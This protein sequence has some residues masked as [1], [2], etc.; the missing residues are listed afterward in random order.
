MKPGLEVG[1]QARLNRIVD[2]S[3]SITLGTSISATV[4]ATPS[5]IH[6]MEYTAT[7][8]LAPY[9]DEGESSVGI[10]VNVEHTAATPVGSDVW[11]IATVTA[12]EK[13]VISFDVEAF[14][15]AGKIGRGKHRRAII[16]MEK[17]AERLKK[18]Q[19]QLEG[20]S[21]SFD[22]PNFETLETQRQGGILYL[23]LNRPQKRNAI[24]A[25]MT[26]E[27]EAL[28]RWLQNSNT[29]VVVIKGADGTFSA[30]DD[31]ADLQLLTTEECRRLSLR[32][33]RLYQ[34]WMY[35]PQVLI[36][37]IDGLAYGGGFVCA[38]AC[39]LRIATHNTLFALPEVKLGWPPNYGMARVAELLGAARATELALTAEAITSRRAEQIGFVNKVVSASQLDAETQQLADHI[40]TLPVTAI[41]EAKKLIAAQSNSTMVDAL[42]ATAFEK[43]LETSDAKARVD[44][45]LNR[46][47]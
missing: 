18:K 2:A 9:L 31:V 22:L 14:D 40:I 17:F 44:A 42:G 37:S 15:G 43:C 45:F 24:N 38:A 21:V 19:V 8:V 35:L 11:A 16:G 47:P 46:G 29:R 41:S 36:A 32:R 26:T 23:T 28:T 13:N 39:D 1:H 5:M 12:I 33:G 6:L 30:G 4:F 10:D 25:A 34:T 3:Q 27:L 7:K 20:G